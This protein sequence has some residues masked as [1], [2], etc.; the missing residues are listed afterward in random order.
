MLPNFPFILGHVTAEPH[1]ENIYQLWLIVIC[2]IYLVI[3][4]AIFVY[5]LFKVKTTRK[6]A[7]N[8]AIALL[9]SCILVITFGSA[10]D[11]LG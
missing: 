4:G 10:W 8:F 7:I 6:T 11:L 9:I 1:T 5:Q 2:D 3:S